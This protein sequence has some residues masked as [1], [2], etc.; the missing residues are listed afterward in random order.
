MILVG[1]EDQATPPPLAEELHGLI[2]GSTLARLPGLAHAP[3]IQDPAGF[4][5]ATESPGEF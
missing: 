1:E 4:V 2:P 5:S 3:Q